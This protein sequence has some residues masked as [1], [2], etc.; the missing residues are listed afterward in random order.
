MPVV[1][2]QDT[3]YRIYYKDFL[4]FKFSIWSYIGAF[5]TIGDFYTSQDWFWMLLYST[6]SIAFRHSSSW[7]VLIELGSAFCLSLLF[8]LFCVPW[9]K[10]HTQHSAYI[11]QMGLD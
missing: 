3:V 7:H 8:D 9:H 11:T 5:G 10:K 2:E 4:L 6:I 1:N